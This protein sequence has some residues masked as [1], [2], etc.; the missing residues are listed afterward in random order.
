MERF[1]VQCKD[2]FQKLVIRIR[3]RHI[4]KITGPNDCGSVKRASQ[5]RDEREIDR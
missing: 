2:I 1:N 3:N 5:T 4:R